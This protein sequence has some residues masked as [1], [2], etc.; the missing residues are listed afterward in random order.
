[1]NKQIATFTFVITAIGLSILAIYLLSTAPLNGPKQDNPVNLDN[2]VDQLQ[3][4]DTEVEAPEDQPSRILE[5]MQL[6]DAGLYASTYNVTLD[7]AERRLR[8]QK[9]LG[10]SL[11]EL[12]IALEDR[13]A[14]SWIEHEPEFQAVV[15]LVG[16]NKEISSYAESIIAESAVPIKFVFDAEITMDI[17]VNKLDSGIP[18]LQSKYPQLVAAEVDSKSGEIVLF[19]EENNIIEENIRLDALDIFEAPVRVE[20]VTALVGD[21]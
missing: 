14:G 8:A 15:R 11:A 2:H 10:D 20:I 13:F 5:G 7:E 6:M 17:L 3:S 16:N 9:F 21:G 19:V 4:S 12:E 18:L 1:M